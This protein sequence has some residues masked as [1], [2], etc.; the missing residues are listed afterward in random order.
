MLNLVFAIATR[1]SFLIDQPQPNCDDHQTYFARAWRLNV[2]NVI[3]HPDLQQA[4]VEGLAAFYL[5]SVGQVNRLV[6]AFPPFL[7]YM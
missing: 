5:L 6:F 3:D 1:H 2:S 7:I 4:Q